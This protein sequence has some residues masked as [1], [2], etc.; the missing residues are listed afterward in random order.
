MISKAKMG[1]NR[2]SVGRVAPPLS[3]QYNGMASTIEITS[4]IT[5]LMDTSLSGVSPTT[6]P[7]LKVLRL[8]RQMS[9]KR[10]SKHSLIRL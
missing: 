3:G 5:S 7:T 2:A 6:P 10:E 9:P 8:I 4:T 1:N